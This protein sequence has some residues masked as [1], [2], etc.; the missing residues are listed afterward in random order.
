MKR[1]KQRQGDAQRRFSKRGGVCAFVRFL[2]PSIAGALL[3]DDDDDRR[4]F[5]NCFVCT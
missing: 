3:L 5:V 2:P 4:H 1:Q